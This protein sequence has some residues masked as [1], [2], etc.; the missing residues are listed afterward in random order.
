MSR[1]YIKEHAFAAAFAIIIAG[2]IAWMAMD[3]QNPVER[4]SGKIEPNTVN[5]G[6]ELGVH[7]VF[8]T[9]RI[10]KAAGVTVTITDSSGVPWLIGYK[11]IYYGTPDNKPEPFDVSGI[12]VPRGI[13]YGPAKYRACV[14]HYCNALQQFLNWPIEICDP[15]LPFTVVEKS[16][17]D[18]GDKDTGARGARGPEGDTGPQGPEGER[19]LQGIPSEHR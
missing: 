8:K 11:G 2:P 7:W 17:S 12:I 18:K 6:D 19:G 15:S 16:D 9:T 5:P 13:T 3:R 14:R 1:H 10:C 4:V